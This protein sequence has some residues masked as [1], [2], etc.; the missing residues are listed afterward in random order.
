MTRA[1]ILCAS[2]LVMLGA[3]G[4][5]VGPQR[6][7]LYVSEWKAKKERP[8]TIRSNWEYPGEHWEQ[9]KSNE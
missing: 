6:D 9:Q 7:R 8:M 2:A 4:C 5:G 1:L 3:A